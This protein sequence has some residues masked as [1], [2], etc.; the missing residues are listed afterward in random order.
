MNRRY[1]IIALVLALLTALLVHRYL[2][3]FGR[4]GRVLIAARDIEAGTRLLP[5]LVREAE[6]PAKAIH[7]RAVRRRDELSGLYA[8]TPVYVGQQ[9]IAPMLSRGDDHIQLLTSLAPEQ[10]AVMIPVAI[11]RAVG[12]LVRVGDYVDVLF[13][14]AGYGGAGEP[15]LVVCRDLRVLAVLGEDGGKWSPGRTG[16]GGVVAAA[17]IDECLAI[18]TALERGSVFLVLSGFLVG[19]SAPSAPEGLP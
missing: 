14:P 19:Y 9:I 18:A 2:S 16:L 5:E 1:W 4:T 3:Q 11:S 12:G 10:R 6:I 7:P 17:T 8:L 13:V 15:A